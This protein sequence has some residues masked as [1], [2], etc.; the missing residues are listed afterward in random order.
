MT[1]EGLETLQNW[2]LTEAEIDGFWY[3]WYDGIVGL[4]RKGLDIRSNPILVRD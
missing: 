3:F 4:V 1:E 2:R